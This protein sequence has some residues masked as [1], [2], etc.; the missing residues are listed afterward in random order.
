VEASQQQ[1]EQQ[2]PTPPSDTPAGAPERQAPDELAQ[3]REQVAQLT[4][5]VEQQRARSP[6]A[7]AQESTGTLGVP[8]P[9]E[10]LP[11][12]AREWP[13]EGGLQL[14]DGKPAPQP[15][16]LHSHGLV[17]G[18]GSNGET[19]VSSPHTGDVVSIAP[20]ADDTVSPIVPAHGRPPLG[21]LSSDPAVAELG[22]L[23]K[24]VGIETSV[25]EG[26][27]PNNVMDQSM[28]DGV[29]RFRD[30]FGVEE[31]PSQWS[32]PENA[33]RHVAAW[34]WEGLLRAVR[35]AREQSEQSGRQLAHR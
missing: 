30:A 9:P 35:R 7:H 27:N 15:W 20:G 31:D 24:A 21:P 28:I 3:L 22:A 14:A 11:D 1:P 17:V 8:E 25:S 16:D 29:Q 23:L 32:R 26:R 12:Y 34:T 10:G 2:P 6:L 5:T 33:E 13:R 4:A 18:N 19:V